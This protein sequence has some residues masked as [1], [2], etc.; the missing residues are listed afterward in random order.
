MKYDCL[1]VTFDNSM[2]FQSP[3]IYWSTCL[4]NFA[5]LKERQHLFLLSLKIY[6][7]LLHG[8]NLSQ[9]VIYQK[10]D[11]LTLPVKKEKK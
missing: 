1:Y 3:K 11:F 10:V 6:N 2:L 9:G 8:T 7:Y 5:A 4:L